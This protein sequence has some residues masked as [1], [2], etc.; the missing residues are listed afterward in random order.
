MDA[1]WLIINSEKK[2]W[3]HTMTKLH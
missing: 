2:S 3:E 1:L